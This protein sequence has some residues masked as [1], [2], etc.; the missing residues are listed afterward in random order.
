MIKSYTITVLRP[1][2]DCT[3]GGESSKFDR[4][5]AV[6]SDA[7]GE[8]ILKTQR[9]ATPILVLENHVPNAIRL[10]PLKSQQRGWVMFGGNYAKGDSSFGDAVAKV[11]RSK[12]RC[13]DPVAIHDRVE[14]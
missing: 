1:G 4:F 10:R 12:V 6:L 14:N 7:D 5:I 9:D 2:Y 8:A 11:M 3:M 13:Y